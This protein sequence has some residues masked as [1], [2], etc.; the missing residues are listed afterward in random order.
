MNTE[1]LMLLERRK[2]IE[3]EGNVY[4]LEEAKSRMR[5]ASYML[6]RFPEKVLT[7]A[8]GSGTNGH[9]PWR[10]GIAK[11]VTEK[12]GICIN[13]DQ[14]PRWEELSNPNYIHHQRNLI[15]DLKVEDFDPEKYAK[16]IG[17]ECGS[18]DLVE[19]SNF[20]GVS[21][22]FDLD[23]AGSNPS[24]VLE[25]MLHENKEDPQEAMDIMRKNIAKFSLWALKENGALMFNHRIYL[26]ENIEALL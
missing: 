3:E 14:G 1:Y 19:C 9:E 8:G 10:P 12:G 26:K 21:Y 6:K 20:L 15:D 18:L 16:E 23:R 4:R 5:L 24:N 22:S 7:F 13:I 11:A 17:C 25:T 2:K